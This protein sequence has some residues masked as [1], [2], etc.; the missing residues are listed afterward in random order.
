MLCSIRHNNC[1]TFIRFLRK[2]LHN[3]P[4]KE[5]YVVLCNGSSHRSK[6]TIAWVNRKKR[7][8]LM[9]TPTHASRRNQIEI[10]FGILTRK[11]VRRG[12]FRSREELAA[13]LMSFIEARN[14]G[15]RSFEWTY[16]GNRLAA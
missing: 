3:Y 9:V 4:V 8:H 11:V 6:R 10:W 7:I 15:A 5:L 2:M 1:E 16:T 14:K 12:I 13:K